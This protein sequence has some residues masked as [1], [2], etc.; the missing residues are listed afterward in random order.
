[1]PPANAT[2]RD[3]LT[4]KLLLM[5]GAAPLKNPNTPRAHHRARRLGESDSASVIR[6]APPTQVLALH[7]ALDAVQREV[8]KPRRGSR[9][10]PRGGD[11]G[12]GR[13]FPRRA[14]ADE[15]ELRVFV[16]REEDGVEQTLARDVDAQTQVEDA[17]AVSRVQPARETPRASSRFAFG[18]VFPG[19][20]PHVFHLHLE[21]HELERR[22]DERARRTHSGG[23]RDDAPV[24]ERRPERV[25]IV[26]HAEPD[27]PAHAERLFRAVERGEVHRVHQH[28]HA[29]R[30]TQPFVRA[31]Q[32]FFARQS[33][34]RGDERG[35][36][37]PRRVIR[38][39][40]D[41]NPRVRRLHAALDHI[42][43]VP[44]H[45]AHQ[46]GPRPCRGLVRRLLRGHR[47][48]LVGRARKKRT[49]PRNSPQSA[50]SEAAARRLH[51][52][53]PL[54]RDT[55]PR[56]TPG[57]SAAARGA[58]CVARHGSFLD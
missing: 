49:A 4:M 46:P 7:A 40:R 34:E 17:P 42:Q 26:T 57:A 21:L 51:A 38:G 52:R 23:S 50:P 53:R 12:R 18:A 32:P 31:P 25:L 29:H 47:S 20:V 24:D 55:L 41:G 15:P 3:P 30:R 8:P 35:S 37:G 14:R 56:A 1:M 54:D 28:H 22:A 11:R 5:E 13:Y 48:A 2:N 36:A 58:K 10:P 9:E 45:G 33:P 27:R 39:A 6:E 16:R 44:E 43:R 19:A